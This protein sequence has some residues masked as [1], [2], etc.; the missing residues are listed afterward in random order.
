MMI[1]TTERDLEN[2]LQVAASAD[3]LHRIDYR[4]P[5]AAFGPLA[6]SR[7]EP[8]LVDARLSAF[9]V[10]TIGAASNHGAL[11]EARTTLRRARANADSQIRR[12]IDTALLAMGGAQQGSSAPVGQPSLDRALEELRGVTSEW[13]RRGSPPQGPTEWR[14]PDWIR[15]FPDHARFLH[16][17]PR[18]LDRTAVAEGATSANVDRAA[19]ESAFILSKAWGEGKNGYGCSRA[20]E[21]FDQTPNIGD[22][23][24]TIARTLQN[25]G[26]LAAYARMC[27]DGDCRI[28]NLGPA[29]GTK[30]LYF[31]QPPTMRPRALIHDRIVAK[32]LR[33]RAGLYLGSDVWSVA[34][35]ATYIDHMHRWAE[36]LECEPDE[37]ELNIFR[38]SLPPTS[39][40]A[41]I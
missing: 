5:I 35:Y 30:F 8:W 9:A 3:G 14:K 11:D 41:G 19:A 1:S 27:D 7:L 37:V 32:W 21:S 24:V 16:K 13:R 20:L 28:F 10:R 22:R 15:S 12:D 36:A 39:R 34:R 33:E 29:F 23:L 38:S 17:Q 40:W 25:D 6:V 4:D 31:A 18:V 2:L 26:A